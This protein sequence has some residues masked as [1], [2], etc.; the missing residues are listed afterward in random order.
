MKIFEFLPNGQTLL[1]F[2]AEAKKLHRAGGAKTHSKALNALSIERLQMPYKKALKQAQAQSPLLNQEGMIP[3]CLLPIQLKASDLSLPDSLG[4]VTYYV[5]VDESSVRLSSSDCLEMPNYFFPNKAS[6][7]H[8]EKHTE[9]SGWNFFPY[10][11]QN[12]RYFFSV[13][14]ADEGIVLDEWSDDECIDSI[15]LAFDEIFE[16]TETFDKLALKGAEVSC[17]SLA[18][19]LGQANEGDTAKL[20]TIGGIE[21]QLCGT[22]AISSDT[23]ILYLEQTKHLSTEKSYIQWLQGE[24]CQAFDG[25]EVTHAPWIGMDCGDFIMEETLDSIPG[26]VSELMMLVAE[27]F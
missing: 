25:F 13:Y 10:G 20:V 11:K 17:Y 12:S 1:S 4:T 26:S 19:E 5:K 8:F 23:E 18:Y 24:D 3:F 7:G 9:R 21:L 22:V 6:L 27:R 16:S 2:K 14:R 15:Y